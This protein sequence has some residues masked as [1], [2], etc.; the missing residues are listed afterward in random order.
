MISG[1]GS[2]VVLTRNEVEH[3]RTNHP[4]TALAI[5]SEIV[6]PTGGDE[7]ATGGTLSFIHP[8]TVSDTQLSVIA[9]IY[10]PS[11]DEKEPWV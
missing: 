6:P 7:P 9:Y 2:A 4:N 8:W 3:V 1:D 5:L 11:P 10:T